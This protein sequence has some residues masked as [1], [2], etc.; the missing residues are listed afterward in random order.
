MK[1]ILVSL[2]P[3]VVIMAD[4]IAKTLHTHRSGAIEHI[5]RNSHPMFQTLGGLTGVVTFTQPPMATPHMAT[6]LETSNIQIS[7]EKTVESVISEPVINDE[8]EGPQ[9]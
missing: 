2:P 6:S 1:K 8:E 3:D 5:I 4:E 7:A 9:E